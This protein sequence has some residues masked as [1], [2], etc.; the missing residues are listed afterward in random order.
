MRRL[1]VLLLAVATSF[2]ASTTPAIDPAALLDHIKL[3]AS[4]EMKGRA[5]G[6]PELE[7][8]GQYIAQ[9]FK[10]AGLQPGGVNGDW[11]QPFE[12]VAGLTVARP[13]YIEDEIG[14]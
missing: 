12:L 4:D 7:R 1:V 5:N 9:E 10:T 11:F 14:R 2:A 8:A 3:L 13:S 6:S